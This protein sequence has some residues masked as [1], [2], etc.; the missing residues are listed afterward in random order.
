MAVF[1]IPNL[2]ARED[3]QSYPLADVLSSF[4]TSRWKVSKKGGAIIFDTPD[5]VKKINLSKKLQAEKADTATVN[6][7]MDSLEVVE[8]VADG[9]GKAPK[10]TIMW[11]AFRPGS[12]TEGDW[13]D[14]NAVNSATVKGKTT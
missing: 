14:F 1:Q 13:V 3:F 4:N 12:G 5:G 8:V 2:P 10:G 9:T 11:V 7:S 6:E